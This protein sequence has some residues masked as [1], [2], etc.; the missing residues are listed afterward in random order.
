M[1][2]VNPLASRGLT[3]NIKSYYLGKTMSA[4]AVIG[5]LRVKGL[6]TACTCKTANM[7]LNT[8]SATEDT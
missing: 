1:F 2:H 4:A 6:C 8:I 5:A 3:R 7:F